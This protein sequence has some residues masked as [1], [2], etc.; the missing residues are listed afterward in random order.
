MKH[1]QKF[2]VLFAALALIAA[3]VALVFSPSRDVL[4][5]PEHRQGQVEGC[6]SCHEQAGNLWSGSRHNGGNVSCVVCHK[7]AQS[8]G[9]HPENAK[10]TVESEETT[11]QVC[12]IDVTG[13]NISG[14]E[15]LSKHGRVGLTCISCHEQHSQGLKLSDASRI[16][17][18]NCHKKEMKV[19]LDSTHY[20]AGLSCV[21][22]HMGEGKSHTMAVALE[23]CGKCHANPHEANLM[24]A[25]GLDV[26]VM[27]TPAAMVEVAPI[28]PIEET[29]APISGGIIM[30][31]WTLVFSGM[32]IGGIIT[33]A[34][35]GKDPG[36]PSE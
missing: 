35:A 9:K 26:K 6:L 2:V 22:C 11:C 17:C 29:T 18:E 5:T 13:A 24:L 1:I 8:G 20:K 14:Q 28:E 25:A 32:M 23:T 3:F 31:A 19:M 16:V 34:L 12:H 36:K 30:P 7:L 33:W 15:A 27:A 10:Y 21:N 4:A